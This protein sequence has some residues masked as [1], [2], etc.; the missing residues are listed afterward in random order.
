ME[1]TEKALIIILETGNKVV[2]ALADDGKISFGEGVSIAMKG[3]ALVGVFKDL[4]EIKNELKNATSEDVALLV[5]T[6]KEKFDLPND[7]A[8]QKIEQGIEVLTQLALMVF[9]P[10][11]N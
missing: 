1:K 8:E 2:D 3:V 10:K 4:P 6:F 7:E 11:V 5:E 9:S